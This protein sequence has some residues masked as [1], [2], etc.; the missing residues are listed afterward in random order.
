MA[1][2][3]YIPANL[4]FR[5]Y[6]AI[7]QTARAFADGYDCKD[8]IRL[9]A[10]LASFV[11]AD[12]TGVSESLGCKT[13]TSEEFITTF[14]SPHALGKKDLLTQHLLGQPY[15][16]CVTTEKIIVEWQ[17]L[18]GHGKAIPD[19]EGTGFTKRTSDRCNGM[20]YMKQVYTK[21]NGEWKIA[22]LEPT[23]LYETGDFEGIRK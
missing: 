13:Y 8:E 18:A 23:V 22:G 15:F 10:V 7:V 2:E 12:Y 17:Q 1:F 19:G 20:S 5:D 16:I 14:L 21:V 11:T 9:R 3:L 4:N 6:I